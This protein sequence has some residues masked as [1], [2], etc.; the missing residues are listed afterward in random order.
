[1]SSLNITDISFADSVVN[2]FLNALCGSHWDVVMF[3]IRYVKN[4]PSSRLL[5]VDKSDTKIVLKLKGELESY[6]VKLLSWATCDKA[7]KPIVLKF[8]I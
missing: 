2:E 7:Y 3:I 1:M 8:W 6:F 4:A 5:Y